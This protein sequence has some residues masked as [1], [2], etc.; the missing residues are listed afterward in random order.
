MKRRRPGDAAAA[1]PGG[2]S[3][4]SFPVGSRL[5]ARARGEERLLRAVDGVDLE[6][7]KGEAL[8]LVGESGSGK[9]TLA[10]ALAGLLRTDRG[11]IRFDG[12][13]LPAS[14]SRADRRRIQMVFQDPY[15][16][17]NPRLTVGGMLRELLRVHHVVPAKRI[18]EYSAELLA[19]VGLGEA[20]LSAYP[21]QFSGGQ[22]Q[23]V[24]IARALALRPD[25][26]VADEPVSALD[27]SV[28]A[29]ILNLLRTCATNSG[30][31]CC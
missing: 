21:R 3:T 27:V 8:A 18:A 13:V 16:S 17:L 7:R 19:L 24:A 5:A 10:Q 26:L 30:S 9:S 2:R 12:R 1:A 23:R 25:V 15:S 31:R 6:I 20:D 14:R 28:Q 11:E 4:A 29:T 22:R